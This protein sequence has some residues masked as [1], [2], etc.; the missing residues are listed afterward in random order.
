[1]AKSLSEFKK[2]SY[3]SYI[4]DYY[5]VQPF[6]SSKYSDRNVNVLSSLVN[7]FAQAMN[8]KFYVPEYVIIFLDD[9]LI[10]HLQYKRMNLASLYRPWIEYLSQYVTEAVQNRWQDLPFK[11][12]P[13]ELMQIYW[14][15]PVAQANFDFLDK[16]ARE[17]VSKCF[18]VNCKANESTMFVLKLHEFWDK[19]DDTLVYNNRFTKQGLLAYWKSMDA[20]FRFN[21][22]KR[23][24]FLIRHRF[25]VL[26]NKMDGNKNRNFGWVMKSDQEDLAVSLDPV[27]EIF[28]C[29]QLHD[30]FHWNKNNESCGQGNRFL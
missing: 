11:A 26:K 13:K 4:K 12:R 14:V 28:H 24:E 3:D 6:C 20:F 23:E 19:S 15:E 1:M 22:Q 16:Q 2:A 30:R 29:R 10:E 21:V 5:D 27:S 18:E 9:N 8:G 17:V 7:S 25:R